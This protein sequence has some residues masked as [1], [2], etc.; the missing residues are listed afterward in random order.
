M[1]RGAAGG[2]IAVALVAVCCGAPLIVAGLA[3]TGAAVAAWAGAWLWALVGAALI[4]SSVAILVIRRR[5][6]AGCEHGTPPSRS[7]DIIG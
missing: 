6:T 5:T 3:V 1:T 4:C 2:V 7:T